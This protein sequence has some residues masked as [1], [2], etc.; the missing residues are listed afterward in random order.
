M[1][2]PFARLFRKRA[3][4]KQEQTLM[5]VYTAALEHNDFDAAK[6]ALMAMYNACDHHNGYCLT[7]L[8]C[9]EC[10]MYVPVMAAQINEE[11]AIPD[12]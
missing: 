2:N 12:V 3:A 8:F 9:P 6:A 4:R 5:E 11:G 10:P 7:E 1:K